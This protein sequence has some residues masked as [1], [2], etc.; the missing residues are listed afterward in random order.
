M[1]YVCLL[2]SILPAMLAAQD[3]SAIYKERCA[4]CH[5]AAEG[6][7]P[8]LGALKAMSGEAILGSLAMGSMKPQAE[9][10][11]P[12]QIFALVGFIAPT[13]GTKIVMPGLERS[14][15]GDS[16][17]HVTPEGSGWNGWSTSVTN[18]RFQDSKAAGLTAADVPKLKLKWA[19]NLGSAATTRGQPVM[20]GGSLFVSSQTGAV[21]ALDAS[22]GCTQWSFKADI[23]LR[24]GMRIADADG[25]PAVYFAD[26]A[27]N[28]YALNA[29]T[30]KVI[31]KVQ[32]SNLVGTMATGT[33]QVYKGVVYQPLSSLE[34]VLASDAKY[35][36]CKFR[37]S[38]V[39]LNA[40]TGEK[41][42]DVHD[43]G[44]TQTD[45]QECV[46]NAAVWTFGRGRMVDADHRRKAG[47]AVCSDGRQ[48]L[49]PA[50]GNKR[51]DCGHGSEDGQNAMVPPAD[52]GRCI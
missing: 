42:A 8:K 27:A 5:D 13:G 3:G 18:S 45:A 25:V 24:G 23:P 11:T 48:L 4:S 31:W 40:A 20:V 46:G 44:G 2:V 49:G 14:C 33:L 26:G 39:A 16:A 29:E 19:L 15:K 32:P 22:T 30:G 38:V 52:E 12:P 1:R 21:Y 9:G 10:L 6:R 51:C 7:A 17:F 43:S 50:V 36:C 35:E 41:L 28:I 34:E 47:D 37:G